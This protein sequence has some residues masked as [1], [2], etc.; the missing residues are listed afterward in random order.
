LSPLELR[1]V[2][3]VVPL[4]AQERSMVASWSAPQSW[5]AGELHPGRGTYL[6]KAGSRGGIPVQMHFV[7]HGEAGEAWLYNTDHLM[8]RQREGA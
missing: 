6:I 8:I 5:Q 7:G 4:S 3:E 2:A 1:K